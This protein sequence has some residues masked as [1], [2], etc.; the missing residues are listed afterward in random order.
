MEIKKARIREFP[1]KNMKRTRPSGEKK[2]KGK[3]RSILDFGFRI[4][5]QRRK[6]NLVRCERAR[7]WFYLLHP[8]APLRPLTSAESN[9]LFVQFMSGL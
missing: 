8:M 6:R 4:E 5:E 9:V 7:S 2:E 3:R 1:D